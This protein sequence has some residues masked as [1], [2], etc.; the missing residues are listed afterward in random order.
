[1]NSNLK[2]NDF[3]EEEKKKLKT[4]TKLTQI[5]KLRNDDND[6]VR[7]IIDKKNK[8]TE[9]NVTEKND[10]FQEYIDELKKITNKIDDEKEDF[11]KK[12]S[13]GTLVFDKIFEKLSDT[14]IFTKFIITEKH[15]NNIFDIFNGKKSIKHKNMLFYTLD[16][17]Q[18]KTNRK[19]HYNIR[20]IIN[21]ISFLM[22]YKYLE[23][24]GN[25]IISVQWFLSKFI[26]LI[27]LGSLLFEEV[28]IFGRGTAFFKNFKND[29]N[30]INLLF[31]IIK[32]NYNFIV[33]N[34]KQES[35][36]INLTKKYIYYDLYFK[37]K[38]IIENKKKLY[39]EYLNTNKFKFL[40]S[41]GIDK[42]SLINFKDNNLLTK[43]LELNILNS[44]YKILSNLIKKNN[45]K[46]CLEVGNN[47]NILSNIHK[48]ISNVYLTF[49]S[50][51][52]KK[53]KK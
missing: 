15:I 21:I 17:A 43:R 30:Y 19:S 13:S 25:I 48:D 50:S 3:T 44:E 39:I 23:K 4:L 33:N 53:I 29:T 16:K 36:I 10:N 12:T 38:L 37:K 6:P 42:R 9:L 52:N 20:F 47:I 32:N 51:S 26:D 46:N 35:E 31:D 2:K 8:N 45:L 7:I 14:P 22:L 34:K 18:S 27:Y 11:M 1:M 5:I 24:N 28:Y 40:Y 49:I 41:I